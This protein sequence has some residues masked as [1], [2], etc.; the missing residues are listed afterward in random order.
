MNRLRRPLL[1]HA[2]ALLRTSQAAGE[3]QAAAAAAGSYQALLRSGLGSMA[4]SGAG[5]AAALAG[6]RRWQH[7]ARSAGALAY[8]GRGHDWNPPGSQRRAPEC[9]TASKHVGACPGPSA[10]PRPAAGGAQQHTLRRPRASAAH[11]AAASTRQCFAPAAPP[12]YARVAAPYHTAPAAPAT[13]LAT[14]TSADAVMAK[15][16][17]LSVPIDRYLALRDLLA[18]DPRA[19]YSLLLTHTEEILPFVYTVNICRLKGPYWQ[20]TAARSSRPCSSRSSSRLTQRCFRPP[21]PR[22]RS[23]LS[24]RAA[25][26][27]TSCR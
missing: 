17:G 26:A 13:A 8:P 15:L 23:R 9:T 10:G 25:S 3:P 19:Y 11:A 27:T 20:P 4:P 6:A 18:A 16:R 7:A 1:A 21:P 5:G 22:N 14:A 2:A 24:A 12:A